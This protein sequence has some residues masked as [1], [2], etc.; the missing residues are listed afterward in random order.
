MTVKATAKKTVKTAAVK[1]KKKIIKPKPVRKTRS[2]DDWIKEGSLGEPPPPVAEDAEKP[3]KPVTV[4]YTIDIPVLLHAKIKYKCALKR[5]P[6]SVEVEKALKR[7]FGKDDPSDDFNEEEETRAD[8]GQD[9]PEQ[10]PVEKE[11]AQAE[12]S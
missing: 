10:S 2:M 9:K 1:R 6:M 3:E 11:P 12:E 7:F 5:K 4:R 8:A